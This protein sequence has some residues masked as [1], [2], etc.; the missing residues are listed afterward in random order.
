MGAATDHTRIPVG[1]GVCGT[2]VAEER[3][4]IVDDVS[5]LDNYLACSLDTVSEIVVLIRDERG[6]IVGQLDLDSDRR[7][8][9]GERDREELG[10]VAAWLGSLF[11]AG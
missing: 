4:V 8:A 1:V 7:A 3:D 5:A 10:R 6:E 11:S 9:F 2:A